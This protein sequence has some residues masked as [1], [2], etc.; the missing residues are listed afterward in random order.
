MARPG[1]G[2]VSLH[3]GDGNRDLGGAGVGEVGAEW[4]RGCVPGL[5]KRGD[6]GLEEQ[7]RDR[8]Q[9]HKGPLLCAHSRASVG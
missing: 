8:G 7:E 1:Q 5:G 2:Q 4:E 9:V 6:T 3:V